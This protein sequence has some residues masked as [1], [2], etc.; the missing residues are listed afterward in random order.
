MSTEGQCGVTGGPGQQD[1]CYPDPAEQRLACRLPSHTP[2]PPT[3][4]QLP[5]QNK[6]AVEWDGVCHPNGPIAHSWL[7]G[8]P[9]SSPTSDRSGGVP[10]EWDKGLTGCPGNTISSC[11]LCPRQG[12]PCPPI[13]SSM[14]GR[15]G[16]GWVAHADTQACVV[17]KLCRDLNLSCSHLHG[18]VTGIPSDNYTCTLLYAAGAL[19]APLARTAPSGSS[20]GYW[21]GTQREHRSTPACCSYS[22]YYYY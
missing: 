3:G 1:T 16:V 6:E 19:Q 20:V 5:P 4:A 15:W 2:L 11:P 13:P 12:F 17:S 21:L 14:L 8:K 10:Q 22:N 9:G 7:G 18:A